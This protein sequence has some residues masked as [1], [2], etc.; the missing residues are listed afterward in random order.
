MLVRL[1]ASSSK[2]RRLWAISQVPACARRPLTFEE[3]CTSGVGD[4]VKALYTESGDVKV[5][6]RLGVMALLLRSGALSAEVVQKG[7]VDGVMD[8]NGSSRPES[9]LMSTLSHLFGGQSERKFV[10]PDHTLSSLM[11]RLLGDAR[12]LLTLIIV[13]SV[14][15]PLVFRLVH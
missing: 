10:C 3:W 5:A 11:S 6:D 13:M 14:F 8:V 15:E 7:L 12:L 1:M 2:E 4:E 9:G